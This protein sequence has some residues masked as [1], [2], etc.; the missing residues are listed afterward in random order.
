MDSFSY[1]ERP[2]RPN[3]SDASSSEEAPRPV[4]FHGEVDSVTGRR[5]FGQRGTIT[6][7]PSRESIMESYAAQDQARARG[8]RMRNQESYEEFQR[9]A[10][11]NRERRDRQRELEL[12]IRE[13]ERLRAEE[14][15]RK[16][17]LEQARVRSEAALEQRAGSR[18]PVRRVVDPLSSQESHERYELSRQAY[19]RERENRDVLSPQRPL[20][21][22]NRE[23]IDGRGSIDSRAFNE[24]QA[25]VSYSIDEND[26]PDP[27]IDA[28]NPKAKWRSHSASDVHGPGGF[29][30]GSS[31][32]SRVPTFANSVSQG[33]QTGLGSLFAELPTFVKVVVPAILVLLI[34]LLLIIFL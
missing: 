11:R 5:V 10:A 24:H 21:G 9:S 14:R 16:R 8:A 33:P 22:G 12:R 17:E 28:S 19:E 25:L 2:L 26:R 23:V 15:R 1:D 31:R 27:M 7:R 3:P 13:E 29:R 18:S 32:G 6:S 20:R 34:I 30:V 4:A